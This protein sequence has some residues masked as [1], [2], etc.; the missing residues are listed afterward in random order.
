MMEEDR[1]LKQ[2]LDK[3]A[4][5]PFVILEDGEKQ[6]QEMFERKR[7]ERGL[8]KHNEELPADELPPQTLREAID[9][10]LAQVER[11]ET[12]SAEAVDAWLESWGTENELPPP[13]PLKR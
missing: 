1:L 5:G 12:I 8:D 3:R 10:A 11:G 7:R 9:E 13:R 6:T 4:N 2:L